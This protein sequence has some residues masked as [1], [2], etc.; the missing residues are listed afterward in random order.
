MQVQ[1]R[2]QLQIWCIFMK[3]YQILINSLV[4]K[5]ERTVTKAIY[6]CVHG[7][8]YASLGRAIFPTESVITRPVFSQY[9]LKPHHSLT[10][11]AKH[12]AIFCVFLS[13]PTFGIVVLSAMVCSKHPHSGGRELH[14]TLID[15]IRSTIVLM[16]SH[17][18]RLVAQSQGTKIIRCQ[19]RR[20]WRTTY[21]SMAK[22]K[23][24]VTMQLVTAVTAV[25]H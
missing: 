18:R 8:I 14:A 10:V 25:L 1:T 17:Y 22:R 7:L 23:T 13:S 19:I 12:E 20:K 6:D 9:R 2:Y 4:Y 21:I 3:D 16:V 5:I 11:R 15:L 24:T